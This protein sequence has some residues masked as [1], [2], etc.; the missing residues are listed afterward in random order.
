MGNTLIKYQ[1]AVSAGYFGFLGATLLFTDTAL[2]QLVNAL[3]APIGLEPSPLVVSPVHRLIGGLMFVITVWQLALGG[4]YSSDARKFFII[5]AAGRTAMAF[6]VIPILVATKTIPS[7]YYVIS[8][9][10]FGSAIPAILWLLGT[11][12]PK[13][14]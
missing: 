2:L 6:G 13:T 10:E 7:A 8:A 14:D 5:S 12:A 11:R 4:S 1:W 3:A 9:T